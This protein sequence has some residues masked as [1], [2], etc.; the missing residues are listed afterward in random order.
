VRRLA[1]VR[2]GPLLA[3]AGLVAGL[4]ALAAGGAAAAEPAS[5]AG[6]GEAALAS[7]EARR[8]PLV[9]A[10]AVSLAFREARD[11]RIAQLEADRSDDAV[12]RER[13]IFLPSASITSNAGYSSRQKEK[14]RTLD[15]DFVQSEYG[16][17]TLGSTNGWVNV[18]L[19]QVLLDLAAWKRFERSQ[20]E[21]EA[22]ELSRDQE[23]ERVAYEVLRRY[24]TVLRHERLAEAADTL[25]TRAAVLDRQAAALLTAG[26]TRPAD[27]QQVALLLEQAEIDAEAHDADA[28][29]ARYALG[30]AMGVPDAALGRPLAS[31]SLPRAEA[32]PGGE[33]PEVL[34]SP[35]LRV[36]DLRRR[37]EEVSVDEARAGHLPTLEV[38]G[39]YSHYGIDRFDNY[40]D[41]YRVGVNLEI[42]LFQGLKT[43]YAVKG[44]AKAAEIARLR[45]RKV[46][47]AKRARVRELVRRLEATRRQPE[48]AR[49]RAEVSLERLRLAE[50]N[51]QAERGTLE[52]AVAAFGES[53]VD[54]FAAVA[55]ELDR[56]L[57]W[58][59]LK[60]ETGTL[61]RTL[62]SEPTSTPGP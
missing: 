48:L 25:A 13:S 49:R 29:A 52:A 50:L 43:R 55:T 22:Q 20:L 3:R 12:L 31:E 47:E 14:L 6:R 56:V 30:V 38:S 35:E 27:R 9:L 15:S 28:Q 8:D 54:A 1:A 61:A 7:P 17:A 53:A 34:S 32:P 39:G 58:A 4:V 37:M 5:A 62:A 45:Y 2:A 44:A 11:A 46:L 36:L 59:E 57:L 26:R 23:R 42:P 51:L 24:L 19:S 18:Y 41:E 16:L 60:R 10:E 21:A 33:P 40:P